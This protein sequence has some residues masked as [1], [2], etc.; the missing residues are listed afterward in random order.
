MTAN[1]L[2]FRR[3]RAFA[4][5]V[6]A[7]EAR[8]DEEPGEGQ[9]DHMLAMVTTLAT[10]SGP[11]L[12]PQVRLTQRALLV[13]EF[14]RAFAGGGGAAAVPAQR[15]RRGSHRAV[16]PAALWPST[17]W[18]RRLA[19]G[20]LASMMALGTL[21]GVAA[22]ATNSLPGDSLYGMKRGLEEWRFNLAGTDEERGR[23]LLDEASTR[24]GE[25]QQLMNRGG[26][27]ASHGLSPQTIADLDRALS[28][29][30]AEGKR[31]RD[32]LNAIYLRSHSLAPLRQLAGF[33]AVQ[34]QA[35][36]RIEPQLPDQLDP[37]ATQVR[38]LLSG[39]RQEV[40]PL[41]PA[42]SGGASATSPDGG[43]GSAS[44]SAS[45]NVNA[46]SGPTTSGTGAMPSGASPSSAPSGQ[47]TSGTG[48]L[49]GGSGLGS[50]GGL[51]GGST[52]SS[53]P[54]TAPSASPSGSGGTGL[55][56]PPLVGGLLPGIGIGV[57]G[58]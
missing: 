51:L 2:E 35:L 25:A 49:V 30:D 11:S 10:V 43:G 40:T 33:A 20:G 50:V 48:S 47:T 13:A 32:L 56:I 6:D 31:G 21:G 16:R 58:S 28:D 27:G 12:D 4:D 38:G 23:L 5:A 41:L 57:S 7:R 22:A 42:Q 34:S 9:Y 37:V 54:S 53:A 15:S 46:P 24:M 39:I 8:F 17:R 52:P 55:T 26:A 1:V 14:E 19:V 29:M 45:G 44:P 36:D 18:G 3:A